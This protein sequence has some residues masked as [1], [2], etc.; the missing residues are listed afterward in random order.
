MYC[1]PAVVTSTLYYVSLT[2]PQK[3]NY[4]YLTICKVRLRVLIICL[5]SFSM[6][7]MGRSFNPRFIWFQIHVS[8]HRTHC[9]VSSRARFDRKKKRHLFLIKEKMGSVIHQ[10]FGIAILFQSLTRWLEVNRKT[11]LP[12][13]KFTKTTAHKGNFSELQGKSRLDPGQ[14]FWWTT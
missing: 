2:G 6:K 8:N 12:A 1:G 5:E 7:M 9:I 3:R 14:C 10:K 11:K 4:S 13:T